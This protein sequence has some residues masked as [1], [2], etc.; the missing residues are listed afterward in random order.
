MFFPQRAWN[1]CKVK[2]YFD[3]FS[4]AKPVNIKQSFK[5]SSLDIPHPPLLLCLMNMYDGIPLEQVCKNTCGWGD[6]FIPFAQS[7]IT[8]YKKAMTCYTKKPRTVFEKDICS[9]I[10][11]F[12]RFKRK[13]F[14]TRKTQIQEKFFC[15]CWLSFSKRKKKLTRV[16]VESPGIS[17]L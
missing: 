4:F 9:K 17:E 14:W 11:I 3:F 12:S 7:S 13:W 1:F 15:E 2:C 6:V 16:R 8:C 5:T 10:R